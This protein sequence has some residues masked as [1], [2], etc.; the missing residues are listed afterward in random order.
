MALIRAKTT[1]LASIVRLG[2]WDVIGSN[3][4][5]TSLKTLTNSQGFF[6]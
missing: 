4:L 2:K 3:P 6:V 1:F 5:E